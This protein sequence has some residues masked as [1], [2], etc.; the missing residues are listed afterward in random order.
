[1]AASRR[2]GRERGQATPEWVG[3]MLLMALLF[4]AAFAKLEPLRL[5]LSLARALG[6]NLLC[7]VRLEDTCGEGSKLEAA[8]GAE[9]AATV[10]HHAPEV[11][12]EQGMRALPVDFRS[13]RSAACSDGAEEGTVWRSRSGEPA[14]AFVRLIDCRAGSRSD[15]AADCSGARAGRTYIQYWFYYPESATLRGVPVAGA[16]GRHDVD[17]ESVQVRIASDGGAETRASSHRGYNYGGGAG[18]WG[19]DAGI[20][21]LNAVAEVVGA[22]APSGWGPETGLVFVSGG[23]HAGKASGDPLRYSRHT[24]AGRLRLIALES[25]AAEGERF[26]VSAPWLKAVWRDPE[27]DETG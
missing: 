10:R 26:A 4:L 5:G 14:T 6:S 27:S 15:P 24:P 9:L 16:R 18:N 11:L 25:L 17:W 13:C 22:R 20:G 2:A 3:L 7:A 8:Y 21:P 1:M 19:S 23:S 12:Y